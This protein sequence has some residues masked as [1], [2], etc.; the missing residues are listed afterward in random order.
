MADRTAKRAVALVT[1]DARRDITDDDRLFANALSAR[2]VSVHAI[3]WSDTSTRWSS[4]D[5][6]VVR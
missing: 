5:A 1:Y 4:F 6:V 2:G 3:P